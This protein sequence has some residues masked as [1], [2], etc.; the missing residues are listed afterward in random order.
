MAA[1][2]KN[3]LGGDRLVE[4][5]PEGTREIVIASSAADFLWADAART[6]PNNATPYAANKTIGDASASVFTFTDFFREQGGIAWLAELK[7][8]VSKSGGITIPSGIAA[9]GILFN[10]APASAAD[11]SG[12]YG[13]DQSAYSQFAVN[14]A[15]RLGFLDLYTANTGDAS[16]DSF[17]L[18]GQP[19][20][21]MLLQAAAAS[22]DLHLLLIATGAWTPTASSVWLPGIKASF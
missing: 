20:M 16:S 5:R 13:A 15:K 2:R 17:S 22:R 8:D 9:R 12:T 4:V 3:L 19:A 14:R 11:G 18:I 10:A 7:V 6:R 1:T 21:P